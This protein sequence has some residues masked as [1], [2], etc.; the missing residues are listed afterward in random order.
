VYV[1][2]VSNVLTAR[3]LS[4]GKQA[5]VSST[6]LVLLLNASLASLVRVSLACCSEWAK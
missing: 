3:I 1:C 2:I 4:Y 5:T 6:A